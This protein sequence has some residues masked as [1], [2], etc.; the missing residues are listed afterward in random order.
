NNTQKT[1]C[2]G[3]TDSGGNSNP[4]SGHPVII[5]TGEKVKDET[6][7]QGAGLYP[8]GLVRHYHGFSTRTG[9]M[10]GSKWASSY[11]YHLTPIGSDCMSPPPLEGP[12]CYPHSFQLDTPDGSFSYT[13]TASKAIRGPFRVS[14]SDKLGALYVDDTGLYTV[15]LGSTTFDFDWSGNILDLADASG[16]SLTF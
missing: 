1:T 13:K 15:T 6:D 10:F 7:F 9:S 4:I 12:A 16:A 11:D 3:A 8:V 5:A 14:G 2:A